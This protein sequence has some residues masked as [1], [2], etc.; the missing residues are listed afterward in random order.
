MPTARLAEQTC[1]P[2]ERV[3][4]KR[5]P[6]QP[7]SSLANTS[8]ALTLSQG[9]H[10][11]L[12]ALYLLVSSSYWMDCDVDP[13]RAVMTIRGISG[14]KHAESHLPPPPLSLNSRPFSQPAANTPPG[15]LC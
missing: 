3:E 7:V 2:K 9:L 8:S 13:F 11:G 5:H 1:P 4:G 10:L 6:A 14:P 12:C 15:L